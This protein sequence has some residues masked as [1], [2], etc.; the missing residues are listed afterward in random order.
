MLGILAQVQG[1]DLG[2]KTDCDFEVG[3]GGLRAEVAN[4][5]RGG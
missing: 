4:C 2:R 1:E 3:G 5:M